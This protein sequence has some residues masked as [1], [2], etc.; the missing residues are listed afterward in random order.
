[1][2][3]G[4]EGYH[5]APNTEGVEEDPNELLL[6]AHADQ[7]EEILATYGDVQVKNVH[8]GRPGHEDDPEVMTVTETRT[9]CKPFIIALLRAASDEQ[10]QTI[11]D[12]Y[13]VE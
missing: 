5:G 2:S 3:M 9:S 8:Y 7:V 11:I 4:N 1:M 10:R 6:Q 12:I 13:K